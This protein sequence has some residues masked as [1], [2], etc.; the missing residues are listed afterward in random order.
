MLL[1]GNPPPLF[2]V[3]FYPTNRTPGRNPY[4]LG[5]NRAS[6]SGSNAI[7]TSACKARSYIVGMPNG[8]FSSFPG[9]GLHTLLVGR[10]FEPS[11]NLATKAK[12]CFGV[13]DLTPSTPAVSLPWL[14]C[15]TLLT[16]IIL[17]DQDF[18][19]VFWSLRVALTVTVQ[20]GSKKKSDMRSDEIS[21]ET[22]LDLIFSR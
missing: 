19:N 22:S 8:R 15:D 17:H 21:T 14:S 2:R 3:S 13:S 7:L 6:H 10:P 11:F 16:A 9:L 12:R 20:G 1:A 4:E 5:S 18:I